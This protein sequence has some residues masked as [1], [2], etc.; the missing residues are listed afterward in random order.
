MGK[1]QADN[2]TDASAPSTQKAAGDKSSFQ[3]DSQSTSARGKKRKAT[4]E[5][6]EEVIDL[7]YEEEDETD[8]LPIEVVDDDTDLS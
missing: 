3:Q 1:E 5:A 7:E 4:G 8:A 2:T 6:G